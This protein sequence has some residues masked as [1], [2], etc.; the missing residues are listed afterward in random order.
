MFWTSPDHA[1]PFLDC[2]GLL[3][4]RLVFILNDAR[5][6]LDS[7]GHICYNLHRPGPPLDCLGPSILPILL[8]KQTLLDHF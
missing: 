6:L 1:G 3:L 5:P 7:P 8:K 4:D 2:P